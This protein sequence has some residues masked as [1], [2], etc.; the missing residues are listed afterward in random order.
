MNQSNI[1]TDTHYYFTFVTKKS[2]FH[3]QSE[4]GKAILERYAYIM[5]GADEGS[6]AELTSDCPGYTMWD[7]AR[8]AVNNAMES[9]LILV[10]N[11][12][13]FKPPKK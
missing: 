13:L 3:A 2:V 10:Y 5:I 1:V 12:V 4:Q 11:K 7:E 8:K 6:L 9:G